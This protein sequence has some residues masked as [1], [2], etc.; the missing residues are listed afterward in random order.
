ML[1]ISRTKASTGF[2][3]SPGILIAGRKFS[4]LGGRWISLGVHLVRDKGGFRI[5]RML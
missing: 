2:E 1:T 3:F 5:G 4:Q